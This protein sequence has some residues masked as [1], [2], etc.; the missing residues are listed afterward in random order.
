MGYSRFGSGSFPQ[1]LKGTSNEDVGSTAEGQVW[2]GFGFGLLVTTC[3]KERTEILAL[4]RK[5]P[6]PRSKFGVRR[7]PWMSRIGSW[8][9]GQT[10]HAVGLLRKLPQ[11]DKTGE[12]PALWLYRRELTAC[13]RFDT[14]LAVWGARLRRSRCSYDT[15]G[16]LQVYPSKVKGLKS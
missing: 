1:M 2:F 15:R 9:L 10:T 14:P 5:S 12:Q 6:P 16:I 3:Q 7:P 11:Q 8:C 13:P 4:C